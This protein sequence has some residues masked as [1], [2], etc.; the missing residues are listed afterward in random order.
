[1]GGHEARDHWEHVGL[2]MLIGGLLLPVVAWFLDLQISYA[3]V[4]WA[5]RQ[6]VRGVLGVTALASLAI[7]AVGTWLSWTCWTRLRDTANPEGGRMVDRS[8][9]LAVAGLGLNALFALLIL[10]SLAPRYFLSP[11]E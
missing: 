4:K 2:A 7:V 6:D 8:Y 3:L 5:C 11:C 10:T 1:M 9:F